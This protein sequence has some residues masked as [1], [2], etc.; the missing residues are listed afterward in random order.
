MDTEGVV[1]SRG[2]VQAI[3]DMRHILSVGSGGY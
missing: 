3:T 1:F 2:G